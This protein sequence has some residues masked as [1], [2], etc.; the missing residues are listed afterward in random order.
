MVTSVR[1]SGTRQQSGGLHR[2]GD[3]HHLLGGG[4]LQVQPRLQRV[5]AHPHVTVLDMPP[6]FAQ[7]NGDAVRACLLGY[8]RRVQRIRIAG[9]PRLPQRGDV[10]DIDAE[11]MGALEDAVIPRSPQV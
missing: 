4:H 3:A 9:A 2:A 11:M 1:F 6:V 8:E 5:L 7:M 10:V